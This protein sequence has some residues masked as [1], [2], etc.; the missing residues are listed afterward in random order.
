MFFFSIIIGS[1]VVANDHLTIQGR[2]GNSMQAEATL[3][4]NQLQPVVRQATT[5]DI[6]ILE[7][8]IKELSAYEKTDCTTTAGKMKKYGF[9][10]NKLFYADIAE[11][12]N[13]PVG[14]SVYYY[15]YSAV[16]GE[17]S[18]FLEDLYV[19]P[20][21]RRHGIGTQ[22]M[23]R[24]KVHANDFGAS[25]VEWYAYKWNQ[26]AQ[27]FYMAIGANLVNEDK[28]VAFEMPA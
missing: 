3:K 23:N 5:N 20:E 2:V 6:V 8:L 24:L 19:K 14:Y 27:D 21:Y 1:Q 11:W 15:K 28:Y 17:P 13:E 12:N 7:S 18:L 9:G 25:S 26:M 4:K 22:L 16:K 10:E